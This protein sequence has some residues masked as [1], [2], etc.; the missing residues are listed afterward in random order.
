[1][2]WFPRWGSCCREIELRAQAPG[3]RP[4]L[5][6]LW[7]MSSDASSQLRCD[8]STAQHEQHDG[9]CLFVTT[10]EDNAGGT[11]RGSRYRLSRSKGVVNIVRRLMARGTTSAARQILQRCQQPVKSPLWRATALLPLNLLSFWSVQLA[12]SLSLLLQ[13]STKKIHIGPAGWNNKLKYRSQHIPLET[14]KFEDP[15][16]C[17]LTNSNSVCYNRMKISAIHPQ[18]T[19]S[20]RCKFPAALPP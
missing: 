3:T 13:Q 2:L 12:R 7:D 6:G 4:C 8:R 15:T 18:C 11:Q 1:M 20:Y 19:S 16:T 17:I 5:S 9:V 10:R 14:P